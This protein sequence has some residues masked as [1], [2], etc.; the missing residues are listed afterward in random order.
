MNV[1]DVQPVER[2]PRTAQR[3]AEAANGLLGSL[4]AKQLGVLHRTFGD[5]RFVWDWLPGE[6]R[7]RIGV[8][9]LHMN[10]SQQ[11]WVMD[12]I[13]ASLD[14]RAA[15]QVNQTR[16]LERILREFEKNSEEVIF[17]VR[18][19][20]QYWVAVFGE[21]GGREPWGWGI[22]GHHV[23]IHYTVV[24]G[25]LVGPW[26]LFIGAEPSTVTMAVDHGL[27]VGFRNLPDEEDLAR[28]LLA[29][30]TPEQRSVAILDREIPWD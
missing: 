11:Q 10:D 12:L 26:P 15:H 14:G 6:P 18:D 23:S 28:A 2:A 19:P 21:P 1:T 9:L 22:T 5:E 16:Q 8:R 27:P 3:M 7:P 13:D 20:E 4:N 25:D 29:T 17:V 24:D 30:F